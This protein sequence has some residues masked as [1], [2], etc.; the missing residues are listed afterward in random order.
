ME[1][2]VI[3]KQIRNLKRMTQKE[4]GIDMRV[5]LQEVSKWER[6]GIVEIPDGK[7]FRLYWLCINKYSLEKPAIDCMDELN[8]RMR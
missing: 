5:G 7:L 4:F 1:T 8:R 2:R 6:V 3:I